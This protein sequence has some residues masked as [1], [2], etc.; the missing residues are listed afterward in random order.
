M[1]E[2]HDHRN[3]H[4]SFTMPIWDSRKSCSVSRALR[5]SEMF[6]QNLYFRRTF[7]TAHT[8]FCICSLHT[9]SAS[10]TKLPLTSKKRFRLSKFYFSTTKCSQKCFFSLLSSKFLKE[11]AL[12]TLCV[13]HSFLCLCGV[14]LYKLTPMTKYSQ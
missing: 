3:Q 9:H 14:T 7:Q 12:C 2:D 1:T 5:P 11:I 6:F 13:Q 4:D 10:S 8:G